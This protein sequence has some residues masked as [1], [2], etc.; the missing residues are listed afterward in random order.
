MI[1]SPSDEQIKVIENIDNNNIIVDSV[2]GSG[3]TT[4]NL[5]I[6]KKYPNLNILLLTYN[7]KL[8]LETRQKVIK[9]QIHNLETHSYHSFCVKYYNRMCF[10]DKEINN[11]IK[12]NTVP[13]NKFKYD[14][15]ILDEAQDITLTYY[16]LI[17]K[18]YQDNNHDAKICLLGDKY[19]S[20]YDF[21]GADSRFIEFGEKCFNL[22]KFPW[23]NCKLNFSF[24]INANMASFVNKCM[25][26]QDRIKS[27]KIGSIPNY[28]ICNTF[29]NFID[30][31]PIAFTKLK[32]FIEKG[33]KP[34]DIFIIAPSVKSAG[35]PVRLLENK[36]KLELKDIPV[37]VPNNDDEEIDNSI[38]HNKLLISTFHQTKGLERKIVFVFNF[39]DSYFKLYK[40]DSNPKICPNE[41]Y[42]AT[43]RASEHLILF[44]HYQNNFLPFLNLENIKTCT[45]FT[46]NTPLMISESKRIKNVDTSP[47]DLCNHLKDSVITKCLSY[48][49]I[50]NIRP[51]QDK[52]NIPLKTK[53]NNN[54]ESV[55]EINGT[56]I[57]I[58]FEYL[59]KNIISIIDKLPLDE[60]KTQYNKHK[61]SFI[62]DDEDNDEDDKFRLHKIRKNID[63]NLE[64]KDLL[65]LTNRWITYKNG[66]LFKLKQIKNYSWL[67][68]SNLQKCIKNLDKLNISKTAIFENKIYIED[69]P[70]LINRKLTGYIDCIDG[71]NL[72]EFKCVSKLEN[73]HYLQLAIYA[74]ILSTV[75][76]EKYNYFL[77]N[78]L[79]DELNKIEF[80]YDD[81]VNM[82][83]YLIKE[84][85]L[86][87]KKLTDEE[88][89]INIL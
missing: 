74:Y 85:Y 84:K 8:K 55:S 59:K 38:I 49:E 12:K 46:L 89:L 1:L 4:T 87:T 79:T 13:I 10:R 66:Y 21:N 35:S 51:I 39:D 15:I 26:N 2:A 25:L 3:K 33:Y 70:E 64:I 72:Y 82:I 19:Q 75:K 67:S 50:K 31:E 5:H 63:K 34:S 88:F 71:N 60:N 80:I 17:K 44:H 6:A 28:I 32:A 76:K 86:N 73:T 20:I 61:Y 30:E 24:R 29:S 45:K 9:Y 40:K 48:F 52:I 58:Y 14:I 83:E 68:N 42:V 62:D 11:V 43:T 36:I 22:N 65:Y 23:K 18:I 56:A 77:Y 47:T 16:K 54:Y 69:L 81:L 78:I 41:L 53:Q 57:P 27:N 7:S 37:Y